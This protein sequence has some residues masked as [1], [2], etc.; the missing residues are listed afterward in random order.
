MSAYSFLDVL[1]TIVGPGGSISLGQDQAGIADEG[2]STSYVEDK[3][4]MVTGAD[5]TPMHSLHAGQGGTVHV[6]LQKT[7]LLNNQL[8]QMFDYQ[9]L[10]GAYW[11]QNTIIVSNFVLGDSATCQICAFKKLP[12]WSNPKIAGTMEWI[13]DAGVIT[14]IFN[15]GPGVSST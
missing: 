4:T 12:D 10:S 9:R 2:I 13:F 8:Q 11:G 6:R 14:E 1:A 3:N 15:A 5:G 7:S